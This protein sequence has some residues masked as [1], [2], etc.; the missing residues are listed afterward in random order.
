[1]L[2]SLHFDGRVITPEDIERIYKRVLKFERAE[3]LYS[4]PNELDAADIAAMT[5]FG[6]NQT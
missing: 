1:M 6:P 3:G 5:K 2:P 4:G